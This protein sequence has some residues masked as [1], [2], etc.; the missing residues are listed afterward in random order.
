MQNF[1]KKSLKFHFSVKIDNCIKRT[2]TWHFTIT[3]TS[4]RICEVLFHFSPYLQFILT[5]NL[6]K[7]ETKKKCCNYS[8]IWTL[9]FNIQKMQIEWTLKEQSDLGL[10]CFPCLV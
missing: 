9:Y 2:W 8:K 1:E 5:V 4:V 6:K 7:K 10:Q 3:S